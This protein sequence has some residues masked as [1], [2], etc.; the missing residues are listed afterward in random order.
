MVKFKKAV[1]KFNG[2]VGALLCNH[3]D[4]IIAHGFAH[5]DK[6]HLCESCKVKRNVLRSKKKGFVK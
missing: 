2:G 1:V 5:K 6:I 4:I 3:C